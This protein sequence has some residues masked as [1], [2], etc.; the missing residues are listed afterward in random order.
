V[1]LWRKSRRTPPVDERTWSPPPRP[2]PDPN[3]V[4]AIGEGPLPAETGPTW[5]PDELSVWPV[6]GGRFGV[7]AHYHGVTGVQRA[8][9]QQA[10]LSQVGLAATVR[11]HDSGGETLRLGPLAHR[12]VWIALEAFLGRPLPPSDD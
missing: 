3:A 2:D 8:R 10:R 1:P 11:P 7:D 4:P 9:R 5:A 6:E 12:A